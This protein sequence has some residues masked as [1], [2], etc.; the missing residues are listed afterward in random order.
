MA[1]DEIYTNAKKLQSAYDKL[2]EKTEEMEKWYKLTVGRE[3]RMAE[4]KQKVKELEQK[5]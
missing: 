1:S 2:K 4:L 5:K 3:V